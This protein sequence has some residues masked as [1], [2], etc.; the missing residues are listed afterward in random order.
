MLAAVRTLVN[1]FSSSG[2]GDHVSDITAQ[3][4]SYL[5][6]PGLAVTFAEPGPS[7][8]DAFF[9]GDL[10]GVVLQRTIQQAAGGSG[11]QPASVASGLL[12]VAQHYGILVHLVHRSS[13]LHHFSVVDLVTDASEHY[14]V[15]HVSLDRFALLSPC[16]I[17]AQPGRYLHVSVVHCLC[18]RDIV[19][20][21]PKCP[22]YTALSR[23]PDLDRGRMVVEKALD[24]V[25]ES[26]RYSL[27]DYN[28]Q[29][30][31]LECATLGRALTSPQIQAASEKMR[32]GLAQS[33]SWLTKGALVGVATA[34]MCSLG[35]VPGV[36]VAGVVGI[37]SIIAAEALEKRN[38]P[39]L[40]YD[41]HA[42]YVHLIRKR[43]KDDKADKE[44]R[45]MD[46][47]AK[48]DVFIVDK[49]G[50]VYV[51]RK[52]VAWM[53]WRVYESPEEK[54]HQD[55]VQYLKLKAAQAAYERR[56]PIFKEPQLPAFPSPPLF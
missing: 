30:F 53:Q 50:C 47:D 4:Q 33:L 38:I 54:A 29:H 27:L 19:G 41:D 31:A 23:H 13:N 2:D 32:Q 26:G 16:R 48:L 56:D 25:D 35:T 46:P 55:W 5:D 43:A 45:A 24:R 22:L 37:P 6:R 18:A 21:D 3:L 39:V 52:Q 36:L 40:T 10:N 20:F 14:I 49:Y 8:S 17:N 1:K 44:A 15:R 51:T 12:P 7:A 28:C 11:S 9:D 34:T 42:D